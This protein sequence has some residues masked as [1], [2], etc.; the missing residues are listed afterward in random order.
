MALAKVAEAASA[1]SAPA[2]PSSPSRAVWLVNPRAG[3]QESSVAST[4]T[5]ATCA[6]S[7]PLR[8]IP[9]I[10]ASPP[11]PASSLRC[12][13]ELSNQQGSTRFEQAYAQL[14]ALETILPPPHGSSPIT[15]VK[16]PTEAP[17]TLAP[18]SAS[19]PQCQRLPVRAL[20][21]QPPPSSGLNK[22]VGGLGNGATRGLN[23]IGGGIRAVGNGVNGQTFEAPVQQKPKRRGKS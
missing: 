17:P 14:D 18:G 19:Q 9:Q 6:S 15:A 3:S 5:P 1:A 21:G 10:S 4:Y 2:E 8:T 16:I 20:P 7:A 22:V 12:S 11:A 23:T 13:P